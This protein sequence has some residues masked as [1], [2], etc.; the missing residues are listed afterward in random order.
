MVDNSVK[1]TFTITKED[2][3]RLELEA[4]KLR[5]TLASFCRMKLLGDKDNQS[6]NHSKGATD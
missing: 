1:L 4:N 3:E 6:V 5:L 2:K